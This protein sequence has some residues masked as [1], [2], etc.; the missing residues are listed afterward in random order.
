MVER[1]CD[2]IND[3]RL[4]VEDQRPPDLSRPSVHGQELGPLLQ[5]RAIDQLSHSTITSVV[6]GPAA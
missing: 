3:Q 2:E 4:I 1:Q 6:D 5:N